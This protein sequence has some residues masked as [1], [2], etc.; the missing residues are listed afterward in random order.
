[1]TSPP[2]PPAAWPEPAP[3]DPLR[4]YRGLQL[5]SIVLIVGG[6]V[7]LLALGSVLLNRI[8]GGVLPVI[9][10]DAAGILLVLILASVALWV[11]LVINAVRSVLVRESLPSSRYRGPSVIILLL[12]ATLVS[13][14][15]SLSVADDLTA[16]QTG[17]DASALG[18]MLA[19]TV[20]QLGLLAVGAVF[21][22][23]PRALDGVRLLPQRG[24][25][26]SLVLG[27][28]LSVPAWI[29]AQVIQ[30]TVVALLGLVGLRPDTGLAERAIA[31]VDP[32]VLVVALVIVAPIAEEVFF[33]GIVFNA[34]E[35]EHGARR[36]LF[37][38]ALL[39]AVI[40]GSVFNL[41]PIFALGVLLAA[42]Y[43]RTRSLPGSMALHAGFNAISV[44]LGLLVRFDVI[45]LP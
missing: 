22:A 45:R 31:S 24:L 8:G 26:R 39:F 1:V 3:L 5:A 38:S 41:L 6:L 37:G 25:L 21:V 29:A 19:L 17:G 27:A 14:V 9:G 10:G 4:R 15:A 12:L 42:F 28:A 13:V 32:V 30:V 40:H 36:A 11:G 16:L 35:R 20:T 43:R 23:I 33:R 18:S 7:T 44:I 34:W 2:V